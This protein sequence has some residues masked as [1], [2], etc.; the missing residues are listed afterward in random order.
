MQLLF[1]IFAG[2]SGVSYFHSM[3]VAGWA[4]IT[5]FPALSLS[6]DKDVSERAAHLFPSLYTE[7]QLGQAPYLPTAY[8]PTWPSYPPTCLP[9]PTYPPTHRP[10]HPP[11]NLG[12]ALSLRTFGRWALMGASQSLLVFLLTISAFGTEYMHPRDGAPIDFDSA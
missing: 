5:V 11:T 9:V 2:F 8:L 7:G 3:Y 6:F 1:N 12:Q 4:V 10:T